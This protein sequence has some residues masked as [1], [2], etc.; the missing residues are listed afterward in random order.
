MPSLFCGL[1]LTPQLRQD[2]YDAL[3]KLGVDWGTYVQRTPFEMRVQEL[4]EFTVRC[5]LCDYA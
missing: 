5:D 1:L 4:R 2:R 3:S